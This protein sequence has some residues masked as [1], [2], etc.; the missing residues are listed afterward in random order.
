MTIN[1]RLFEEAAK[2]A[3]LLSQEAQWEPNEWVANP[4]TTPF[5]GR[6]QMVHH[7][8]RDWDLMHHS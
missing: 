6:S 4:A 1:R 3:R 8:H 2:I 7:Q 5:L